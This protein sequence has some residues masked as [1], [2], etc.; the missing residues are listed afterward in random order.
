MRVSFA[1]HLAVGAVVMM[2][3]IVGRTN[4][5]AVRGVHAAIETPIAPR[6]GVLFVPLTAQRHGDRWPTSLQLRLASGETIDAVVAWVHAMPAAV[7]REWTADSYGVAI[8]PIQPDDDSS[9]LRAPGEGPYLLTRLPHDGDGELQFGRQTLR[10]IW[11]DVPWEDPLRVAEPATVALQRPMLNRTR[12]PDRPDPDSPF[13]YWRWVLLADRL[14]MSPPPPAGSAIEQMVAEH[15]ASLW[16]IGIGRLQW[17]S[18]RI[19][20]QCRE[21]LTRTCVDRRQPFAA[22]ITDTAELNTLLGRLLDFSID[23]TV[24]LTE[25][26][27]WLDS[28]QSIMLWPE[29]AYP[30]HVRIAVAALKPEPVLVR[31]AWL[32]T[33]DAPIAERIEP[34]M[35]TRVRIP[36]P[37]AQVGEII[38]GLPAS[39]AEPTEQVLQVWTEDRRFELTFGPPQIAA[40][41]PGVLLGTFFPPLTLAEALSS[42]QRRVSS[43]RATT[44]QVRRLGGRWEVFL[45]CFRPEEAQPQR[46]VDPE[47]PPSVT[48]FDWM[49]GMEA[50]AILLGPEDPQMGPGVWLIVPENGWPRVL[51]GVND[52]TL[53][54]HKQS[55][56]DRWRCRIVLPEAWFS[57]GEANPGLIGCIRSHGDS[58]QLETAPNLSTPWHPTPSR[59]AIDLSQ[60]DDLPRR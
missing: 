24:M 41:P 54:V 59:L 15:F 50:V 33:N 18:R 53:Q 57:A 27:T 26:V 58:Q 9:Q 7:D 36:R 46:P 10:P 20:E 25:V 37:Q 40:K 44:A 47:V 21:M 56:E 8:R 5:E 17:Q 4:A 2:A 43:E 23:D 49:R 11:R 6:G 28:Q 13:E 35:L 3:L 29:A 42:Q 22:W 30:D 14:G 45:E 48:S 39:P 19:A 12:A 31:F 34:G 55:Y 16:R 32:G 60:W 52:G 1:A 38:R 51:R